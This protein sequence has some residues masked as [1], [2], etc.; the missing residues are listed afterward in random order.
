MKKAFFVSLVSIVLVQ[1][2]ATQANAEKETVSNSHGWIGTETVETK[3][4]NFEFKNAAR[5]PPQPRLCWISSSLT[6][7]SRSTSRS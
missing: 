1:G 5:R 3:F 2:T 7:Q 4:G 6:G